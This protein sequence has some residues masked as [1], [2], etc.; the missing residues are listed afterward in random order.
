M[1]THA[2]AQP[3]DGAPQLAVPYDG[4]TTGMAADTVTLIPLTVQQNVPN[5]ASAQTNPKT[6]VNPTL[7]Q[8]DGRAPGWKW[9]W[10][11]KNIPF[12]RAQVAHSQPHYSY[13][14]QAELERGSG[15]FPGSGPGQLPGITK[16][17]RP[18]QS[19]GEPETVYNTVAA[20]ALTPWAEPV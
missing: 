11:R 13:R 14:M 15:H 7:E 18:S 4:S 12:N 2:R 6:Q 19:F 9:G 17:F 8:G 5:I 10:M 3:H 1:L 20:P 16:G